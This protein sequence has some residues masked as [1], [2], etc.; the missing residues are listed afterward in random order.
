MAD[1]RILAIDYDETKLQ[2]RSSALKMMSIRVEGARNLRAALHLLSYDTFDLILIAPSVLKSQLHLLLD[3]IRQSSR[4]PVVLLYAGEP[5]ANVA[6]DELV[7]EADDLVG[8]MRAIEHL[9]PRT[10]HA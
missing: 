7:S 2:S 6:A 5:P 10:T 3:R 8:I 1:R 9:A 4:T